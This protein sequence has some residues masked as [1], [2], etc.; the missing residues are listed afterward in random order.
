MKIVLGL[1]GIPLQGHDPAAA[2]IV[3]NKVVAAVEEERL[4]RKKR[5]M[6]LAPI[7][8]ALEV[9]NLAG[10]S[11][12]DVEA[13]SIP[14]IPDSMGYDTSMLESDLRKWLTSQGFRGNEIQICFVEHHL[15][16]AWSGLAYVSE[17]KG[18]KYSI[19][20]VDGSGESTGGAAFLYNNSLNCLW[21]IDQSSSLGIYYE[22]VSS[23]IGFNWGEEGK[24]MGLAAYGRDMGLDMPFIP[25]NRISA[26]LPKWDRSLGSPK[27]RH[28]NFREQF[29]NKIYQKYGH[30]LSF[31]KKA[32]IS[33]AA[34]NV[35]CDR[36]MEYVKELC[37]DV[38]GFVLA[39]GVAL[40]CSI[41][42][43]VAQYCKS[44][45]ID[46]VIPPPASDTGVA[47]GAAIATNYKYNQTII[48]LESAYLGA[49]YSV[50]EICTRLEKQNIKVEPITESQ[51]ASLLFDENF[52]CGWFDGKSEIGP[53]ALG[54][55]CIIARPDSTSIRDKINVLKGRESWRPLAPSVTFEEF[56]RS[57]EGSIP[58]KYM[59]IN[60]TNSKD[61]KALAGVTHVDGTARPQVVVED[62][63][64]L[65][66]IKS[67]G[68]ITGGCEAIICTSFNMAGEP[69]VYTPED[70]IRSASKMG[71]DAVVGNGWIVKLNK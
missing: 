69:I 5:G 30:P 48:P 36:I 63:A 3:D 56:N 54:H 43:K 42:V 66:L 60:A 55:R 33:L 39:G 9:V 17:L 71:L 25:D 57:F 23:Y 40:N 35:V 58:S 45:N 16:H 15:A 49:D 44:N 53:R 70:A 13:V 46:F 37:Q 29:V 50:D 6:G 68:T 27:H 21:H 1:N 18:K 52:I 2:L 12:N 61:V 67:V 4:C 22:A 11:L 51:V 26:I 59:L 14:W 10:L 24:T 20:V 47:I 64:Y 65:S 8:A 41:N 62:G 34:Q 7:N 38:D 28:E 32:D 31:N 19:L